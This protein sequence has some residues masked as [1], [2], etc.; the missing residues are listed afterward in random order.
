METLD[1]FMPVTYL[2]VDREKFRLDLPDYPRSLFLAQISQYDDSD[3]RVTK[4]FTYP[5]NKPRRKE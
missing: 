4:T 1:W 5:R 3:I 2:M